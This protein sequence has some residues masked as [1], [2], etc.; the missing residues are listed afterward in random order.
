MRIAPTDVRRVA[1]EWWWTG[2]EHSEPKTSRASGTE[3]VAGE[4]TG[5][6]I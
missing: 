3:A 4:H 1:G 5:H 6:T 2:S